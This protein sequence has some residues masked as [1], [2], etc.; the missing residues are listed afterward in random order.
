MW[1]WWHVLVCNEK[2]LTFCVSGKLR[3]KGSRMSME[4]FERK[5]EK[6]TE[7]SQDSNFDVNNFLKNKELSTA[8]AKANGNGTIQPIREDSKGEE[9][10]LPKDGRTKKDE[11]LGESFDQQSESDS[12]LNSR[13]NGGMNGYRNPGYDAV[14]EEEDKDSLQKK[15]SQDELPLDAS[16][17]EKDVNGATEGNGKKSISKKVSFLW[18]EEGKN[19]ESA[20]SPE[21]VSD[22][23]VYEEPKD[24]S[25]FSL[26]KFKKWISGCFQRCRLYMIVNTKEKNLHNSFTYVLVHKCWGV[27]FV[28]I[29]FY[30]RLFILPKTQW[31]WWHQLKMRVKGIPSYLQNIFSFSFCGPHVAHVLCELFTFQ[32]GLLQHCDQRFETPGDPWGLCHSFLLVAVIEKVVEKK[33][34]RWWP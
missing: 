3:R 20:E 10:E 4:R 24:K 32:W 16:T 6:K 13:S 23:F 15:G 29:F 34:C 26:R 17:L 22:R 8:E 7:P 25:K 19:Q 18:G 11:G 14:P 5:Y 27:S 1:W 2:P 33:L 30:H 21:P 9:K 28:V 12:S 31:N